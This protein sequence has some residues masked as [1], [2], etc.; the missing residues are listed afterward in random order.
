MKIST[1]GRYALEALLYM[2][3]NYCNNPVSIK[4][5]CASTKISKSYLE[6]LFFILRKADIL[7]T[8][9]GPKGGYYILPELSE[10]TVG[11]IL[12]TLEGDISPVA[13]AIDKNFCISLIK[14]RCVTHDLWKN[15]T[16][17]INNILDSVTM[18]ELVLTYK[19]DGRNT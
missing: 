15:I 19:K 10:L 6:Q 3:I 5:I 13:C 9:R 18:A 11:R 17:S 1:K 14:N 8:I 4:S 12:R 16:E 7:Q 2:G